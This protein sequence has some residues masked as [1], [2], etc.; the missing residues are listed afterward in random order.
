MSRMDDDLF[1]YEVKIPG[2]ASVP[3]DLNNEDDSKQQM[4][5]GSDMEYDPSNVEFT[6]WLAL[7]FYNDKTMD[8]N[9]KNTLS[10]YWARGDDE[11][12]LTNEESSDSD[13]E[14]EVAEIFRID[15]NV[16][17][18]ETSMCRASQKEDTWQ[19]R[20]GKEQQQ[21][22]SKRQRI[23]DDKETD[24]H[25]EVKVDDEVELKKHLV[26]V[27]DDD[28]AIDAIPLATKPLLIVEYK[29]LKEGI[30]VLRNR[31]RIGINKWYQSFSLR[32]FDLE[33][34]EFKS[35]FA[36]NSFFL[37]RF[38]LAVLGGMGPSV[39]ADAIPVLSTGSFSEDIVWV[40]SDCDSIFSLIMR[41]CVDV[42]LCNHAKKQGRERDNKNDEWPGPT[43][44]KEGRGGVDK[45]YYDLRDM[46]GGHVWRRILPPMLPRSSSGYDMNWVIVD[47]LTKSACVD[48]LRSWW[49]IYFEAL[50]DIA[51][52]IENTVKIYVR[53]IILKQI[54]KDTRLPLTEFSIIIVIIWMFDVLYL[55]LCMEGSV[56]EV[57][58]KMMLEV[59]SWK[60]VVHLEKKEMLAP[61]YVGPFEIIKG[62]CP[63]AY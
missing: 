40:V 61:I 4:T 63:M 31:S 9:T 38:C 48:H 33:D 41:S 19:E 53:L 56:V 45:T 34:M 43:N 60:D 22:S 32:N 52:G 51:E 10:I 12:E 6:K 59:S 49:K 39:L 23:E 50:V 57:G 30:M 35:L 24:E 8:Q 47:R 18:F 21:E 28:I 42:V 2:L 16:F 37:A 27:K 62:I 46:Y 58:D 54:D 11:V 3:C 29:L 55:K 1:T 15:N 17:D 7:K 36:F 25:E 44:G 14:D 20:V 26:I 13:D 5:H